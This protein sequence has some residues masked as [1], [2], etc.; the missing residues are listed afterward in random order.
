M[1]ASFSIERVPIV[2]F[3]CRCRS[4]IVESESQEAGIEILFVKQK[5]VFCCN[6]FLKLLL[7]RCFPNV[8]GCKTVLRKRL[9]LQYSIL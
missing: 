7:R 1:Y 6:D 8:K 2:A 9:Q 3:R 5:V 4:D